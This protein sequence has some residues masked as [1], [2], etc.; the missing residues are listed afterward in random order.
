MLMKQSAGLDFSRLIPDN[1]M[2]NTADYIR[3]KTHD[4][5]PDEVYQLLEMQSKDE[6]SPEKIEMLRDEYLKHYEKIVE[7]METHI[8]K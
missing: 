2:V 8:T 5:L 4:R 1:H 7:C 3:E 6:L